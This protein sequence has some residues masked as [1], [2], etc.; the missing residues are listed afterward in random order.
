MIK[1]TYLKPY[2][3]ALKEL[4]ECFY[5][6]P[7]CEAGGPLHVLLDDD[8]YDIDS[9]IFCMCKSLRSED[10]IVRTIGSLICREYIAMSLEERAVFDSLRC[11]HT[12]ECCGDCQKCYVLNNDHHEF[13]QEA[14]KAWKEKKYD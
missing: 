5:T 8:N 2:M 10:E 6:L 11:G 14:E 9:V 12:M 1:C 13:M 3:F 4:C 7:G